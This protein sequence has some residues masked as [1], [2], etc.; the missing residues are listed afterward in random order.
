MF[1]SVLVSVGVAVAALQAHPPSLIPAGHAAR[2]LVVYP[3][4]PE[5][6]VSVP[7]TATYLGS[8]RFVLKELTDCEMHIF[9][10]ADANRNV[11]RFY[12]VHFESY[13]ASKPT[14][15]MTYGDTDRRSQAWGKTIWVST[16]P[17]RTARSPRPGSDTEH[18]RNIIRR[19]GYTM[20]AGMMTARLARLLDDPKDTGYGRHEL[21]MIYGEDLSHAGLI[22]GDVTT[23][24]G[25]NARWAQL[26]KP[27]L[28]RA[29]KA[30]H[31]TAS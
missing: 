2:N 17:A 30:F 24:G 3:G 18:F 9:V 28:R 25:P 14:D 19:A 22:Y 21:M 13:L 12:W 5:L 15:H 31:V 4:K 23:N 6:R 7:S 1:R 10:E 26:E 11:R 29:V 16:E 8:D 27:L 20:P